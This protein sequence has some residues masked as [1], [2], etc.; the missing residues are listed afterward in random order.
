[1]LILTLEEAHNENRE[2]SHDEYSELSE[3]K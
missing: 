2:Q 3:R 1:M